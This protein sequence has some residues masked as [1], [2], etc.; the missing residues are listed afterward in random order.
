[1]ALFVLQVFFA[2]L[3]LLRHSHKILGHGDSTPSPLVLTTKQHA[4]IAEQVLGTGAACQP[5]VPD[6]PRILKLSVLS[7]INDLHV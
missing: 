6:I 7:A 2:A 4:N 3:V 1:M 5:R